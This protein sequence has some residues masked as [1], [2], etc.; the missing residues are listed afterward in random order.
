MYEA[1]LIDDQDNSFYICSNST[2]RESVGA[3]LPHHPEQAWLDGHPVE[4]GITRQF[5]VTPVGKGTT[6]EEQADR[7][8]DE[9]R[10]VRRIPGARQARML[11]L[12]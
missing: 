4:K 7:L 11:Q 2:S 6:V 9:G 10:G 8:A 5:V 12:R 1:A 3:G